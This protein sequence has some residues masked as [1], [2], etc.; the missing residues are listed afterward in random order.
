MIFT[1]FLSLLSFQ[2]HKSFQTYSASYSRQNA[3]NVDVQETDGWPMRSQLYHQLMGCDCRVGA[4]TG[5]A[6]ASTTAAEPRQRPDQYID[7]R[8]TCRTTEVSPCP[9][10]PLCV[11]QQL[12]CIF[13]CFQITFGFPSNQQHSQSKCQIPSHVMRFHHVI[14]Q[15]F[16][17]VL[18]QADL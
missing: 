6:E 13:S 5:T 15:N 12:Q 3:W 7:L 18:T 16:S 17:A 8:K 1:Q 2:S 4:G 14:F 11:M 10:W 9:S